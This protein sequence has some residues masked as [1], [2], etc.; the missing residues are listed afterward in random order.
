MALPQRLRGSGEMSDAARRDADFRAVG[1]SRVD[2]E[3]GRLEIA[4]KIVDREDLDLGR[5]GR[6]SDGRRRRRAGST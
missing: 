6:R 2:A 4:V 1:R 3:L 5:L